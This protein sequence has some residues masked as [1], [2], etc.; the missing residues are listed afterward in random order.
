MQN[1]QPFKKEK[2]IDFTRE[3]SISDGKTPPNAVDF[4]KLVIGT[5]LID[6][7]A[8][9]K[10]RKRFLDNS[11]IFYDPKHVVIFEAICFLNDKDQPVDLMT[12]IQELKRKE[13]LLEAGGDAYVI[14]LS[15]G[16]SS[17]AHID[18]H[19]MIVLQ[20][21]LARQMINY[22]AHTID[23]LF[24]ESTD[25]IEEIDS[26]IANINLIEETIARQKEGR[27]TLELHKE[28]I[29]MQR[30]KVIPGIKSK[31]SAIEKHLNG[32]RN[33]NLIIV[34]ARPAMG[35][36]TFVL[37][38]VFDAAKRGVP[39]GFFS[40][41]M[42]AQ[43][44]HQKMVSNDTDING[45]ALRDRTLSENEM[46]R[47]FQTNT[48]DK[49]PFYIEDG[50]FDLNQ[51]LAK[52]RLMAKEKGV[53]IIAI[54]YLQLIEISNS[55]NQSREQ[56]I[57]TI[58]RKLKQLAKELQIPVIALSQLSRGLEQRPNKRPLLSD[59][60]ESGAIEQDA[61][62]VA[63][64]YRPEYY[65]IETWD[66]DWD[67]E[68][69]LPTK[70]EVEIIFAK[71]RGGGVFE[72]RLKFRGD[73]SKFYDLNSDFGTYTNP[74][75]YGNPADAFGAVPKEITDFRKQKF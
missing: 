71:F 3:L 56:I 28:L 49:L 58:S 57:S 8:I 15:M 14:D 5:L 75:P 23:K 38:D 69:N 44:L 37:D 63:F 19:L 27:T 65:K 40:L 35:K 51:I 4:E 50:V 74:V 31:H 73:L 33:G 41:E 53:K 66:R 45:N 39:V 29:Q 9:D 61:D 60:R 72:E 10:V 43:E 67:G 48:F 68:D 21:F 42:S 16:I 6:G 1:K 36:T 46:Q 11:E 30:E 54:D 26:H 59:L 52:A 70:N 55:K 32:W 20:K 25:A 62:I 2:P 47:L 17:S 12:V 24:R 64:L 34:G 7:Q 18:Y 22:C 13:K